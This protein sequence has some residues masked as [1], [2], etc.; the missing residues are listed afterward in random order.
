ML[1]LLAGLGM[2]G[3]ATAETLDEVLD[4]TEGAGPLCV[5]IG[6][7]D[8]EQPLRIH[9]RGARLVQ[10]LVTDR[11]A[12]DAIRESLTSRNLSGTISAAAWAGD[13]LPYVDNLVNL[14]VCEDQRNAD[15]GE[16]LR[17]VCPG[18][19]VVIAAPAGCR[20]LHKPQP[21]DTDQ[22][23]HPWHAADGG[24]VSN[25][26]TIGVPTGLQWVQGPLFAMAERKS[27]AQSLIA[28]NGRIFG[29]TQNVAE[30]LG[31]DE[32]DQYLVARDAYNG[33]LLW[34]RRW[35]APFVR[36][37]GEL[38][39]R[40][41]AHDNTLLVG[42]FES[43]Q[44]LDAATGN[45]IGQIPV[46]G[47]VDNVLVQDNRLLIQAEGA[48]SCHRIGTECTGE[49]AWRFAEPGL[50]AV[51][52]D[53]QRVV[54][55]ATG[56]HAD[57]RRAYRI[58]A[59]GL[60]D[61]VPIWRTDADRFTDAEQLRICFATEGYVAL[62]AHGQLH[63]LRGTTG[64]HLWS[65]AT[66]A[67]PGKSYADERYVGHFFRHGLVWMQLENSPR[68]RD[69]QATW[70]AFDPETGALHRRLTTSEPWPQTATPAKMGCQ[71]M[72]ASDRYLMIP[73]QATFVDF[74]SGR[75]ESFKF[76]RGGCG[77]GFVPANGLLYTTPHACGCY[78][79]TLRGLLAVHSRPLNARSGALTAHDRVERF[80]AA[81]PESDG[82]TS[83]PNDWPMYRHDARRTGTTGAPVNRELA[84]RWQTCVA[85]AGD[86]A[87]AWRLRAGMAITAPVVANGRVFVGD[88]QGHQ[89]IA[90]DDR[91][92]AI[93]WRF[94]AD[95][96]IDSPP[97]ICGD[98]C[99]FGSRDGYV[100]CL[101]AETG[102]PLWRHLA[103]PARR[104]IAAFGQLESVW[105]VAGTV[106]VEH[107]VAYAAAGRAPDADGG[108]RVVALDVATGQQR[109][110]TTASAEMTGMCDYLV[111]DGSAVYLSNVRFD[112][113]TGA[114]T[115]VDEAATHLRGGK[116]G[117]LEPSWTA[118]DLALRKSI[119]DWTAGGHTGQLLAFD[120][121]QACGYRVAEGE[122]GCLFGA[123]EF[124]WT[125]EIARPRQVL[126]VA[127][128]GNTI[129]AAG[130]N[131]RS[132]GAA[133]GFLQLRCPRDG[134]TAAEC[135]FPAPPVL[136]GVAITV[137]GVYVSLQNGHVVC[138]A[139]ANQEVAADWPMR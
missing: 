9:Q 61:G 18:G 133:G 72:I 12:L 74:Q 77:L 48:L 132:D 94:A 50:N 31:R 117:L 114:Q 109:W 101:D 45:V 42:G 106:L 88:T 34:K 30:N 90:I 16:L 39:P 63:V 135:V 138:L 97:T 36:G 69:G 92:G 73:R 126:A 123:G 71:L 125:A 4:R 3:I 127:V 108:I 67:R 89:V 37:E 131:D 41:V 52:V 121:Q 80:A 82:R 19:A 6:G 98:R 68:E 27:S 21:V 58:V 115:I 33:L 1:T 20:V 10:W 78:S 83:V 46:T 51:A 60:T 44:L 128:G 2:A 84:V 91:S 104:Q 76:I 137:G 62:I 87:A 59:L 32:K 43:V 66:P 22:W 70:A 86:V 122:D 17:V 14:L 38:N 65:Q 13:Q 139:A 111:S 40:L 54:V 107:G 119:Q 105:P 8:L 96:R 103:A 24:L 7:S 81:N 55:L 99:L 110:A 11:E 120:D 134:V 47:P 116:A 64:E 35:Q 102:A 26:R 93:L 100:Y 23:T 5:Y 95:A 129:I 124:T 118:H 112:A 56:R 75:K 136:D 15:T 130:A 113:A 25:D 79:E 29:I 85:P 53:G 57:G 49:P 28:A